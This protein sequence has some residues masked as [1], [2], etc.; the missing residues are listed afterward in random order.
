[1]DDL[2]ERRLRFN[3]EDNDLFEGVDGSV[4]Q[5]QHYIVA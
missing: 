2:N 3:V 1:M 5:A 4:P